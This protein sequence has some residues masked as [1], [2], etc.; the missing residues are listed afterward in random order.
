MK[1]FYAKSHPAQTL[2]E[3]IKNALCQYETFKNIHPTALSEDEL[4]ML[5]CAVVSHDLGKLDE[6]FQK[7]IHGVIEG[8]VHKSDEDE[9]IY[10][11][12]LSGALIDRKKLETDFGKERAAVILTAVTFHHDRERPDNLRAI[13]KDYV[14]KHLWDNALNYH[15]DNYTRPEKPSVKYLQC[16]DINN[17]SFTSEYIKVKGF[18]NKIDYCASSNITIEQGVKYNNKNVSQ[19]TLDFL[20]KNN[21][22]PR[23]LQQFM[24]EHQEENLVVIA[25]TGSGK[26]EG[27]LLWIGDSKSFYTLPLKVSINA[28]YQRITDENRIEY[29]PALLLHSDALSYYVKEKGHA[30]DIEDAITKHSQAKK[31][32]APMTVCTIDQILKCA[33]KYNGAEMNLAVLSHSKLIIDEIQSYSPALMGIIIYALKMITSLGG[34]FAIVTATF[35]KL[36]IELLKKLNIDCTYSP[37]FYGD[38]QQRHRIALLSESKFDTEQIIQDSQDKKVLIIVN[39]VSHAQELY[40]KLKDKSQCYLLHSMFLRKDRAKLEKDILEFA[41]NSHV[42]NEK[43]GIWIS[44]QIV[45]ASLDIDFDVLYTEMCS[46]DSLLQRMGRVYRSRNYFR[47]TPNVYILN[48][49]N[50]V[51]EYFIDPEI[52]DWSFEAV[53]NVLSNQTSVILYEG[54]NND[55]KKQM[56]DYVYDSSHSDSNYYRTIS[57]KIDNLENLEWYKLTKKDADK[58]FREIDSITICPYQIYQMLEDTGKITEWKQLLSDKK[59]CLSDKQ[60]TKDEI[61]EYTVSISHYYNLDIDYDEL[62]YKHS[63]IYLY[64]GSYEFDAETNTGCGI[65]KQYRN[66]KSGYDIKDLII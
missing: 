16:I 14:K 13:A 32:S 44:T 8:Y 2:D 62:F 26:T 39:T 50:G 57:K 21:M 64:N 46:I 58:Y 37:N 23:K 25:S 15:F 45:E 17:A 66:T 53:E 24:F 56:I 31:L 33:Y 35:P 49:R 28:I 29:K 30:D 34:K 48:N 36:I 27:A 42:K 7:K 52:Y 6:N 61:M 43:C 40:E 47:E 1:T 9:Y 4:K 63:G 20:N 5:R 11:N 60:K 22:K 12:F 54:E 19:L 38:F 3:H 10:H 65:I 41:P 51:N 59:T 18:L 55:L